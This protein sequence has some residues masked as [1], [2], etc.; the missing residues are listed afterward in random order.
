MENDEELIFPIDK[1]RR[2]VALFKYTHRKNTKE[3]QQQ[4]HKSLK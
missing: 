1:N 4:K 3:Y 2:H